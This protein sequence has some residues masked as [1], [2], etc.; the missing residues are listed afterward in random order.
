[1]L[2]KLVPVVI[3][4][5]VNTAISNYHYNAATILR[6]GSGHQSSAKEKEKTWL[7]FRMRHDPDFTFGTYTWYHRILCLPELAEKIGGRKGIQRNSRLQS[8]IA[9]YEKDTF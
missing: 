1:V 8:K 7:L 2:K 9:G 4:T 6:S 3:Q 5:L